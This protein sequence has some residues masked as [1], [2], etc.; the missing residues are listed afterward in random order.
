MAS[1]LWRQ[2]DFDVYYAAADYVNAES[3]VE[4]AEDALDGA[5]DVIAEWVSEDCV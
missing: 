1:L 2:K 5:R 4:K 3:G